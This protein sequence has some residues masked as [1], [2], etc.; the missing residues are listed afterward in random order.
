MRIAYLAAGAAN[1]FCGSCLHD[2]TLA[3]ALIAQ[4]ADI[5]LIPT[6][7]PMRVDEPSV[8]QQRVF[9][10]GVNVYLQDKLPWLRHAPRFLDRWLDSSWLL[11]QLSR[12]N[13]S[14]DASKLG[15]LTVSTLE[16]ESGRVRKELD[17][18]IDWLAT[19]VRP[20][21]VHLSNALLL[22]MTQ[23]L[24]T[25]L[26]A[27]VVC[28]LSGEDIFLEKLRPPYYE[29]SL[30]LMRERA[31]AADHFVALNRYYADAMTEL[32]QLDPQ[33][34]SVVPHG[35]KLAGHGTRRERHD[36]TVTVGYLARICHDKGLHQLVEAFEH[37]LRRDDMP[38][39]RLRV[40]GYLGRADRPYLLQ[41]EKRIAAAGWSDR[42]EYLGELS[43][44][45]KIEFLQSLDLFSVP[46]V[47]RESKGLSIIEAL[48]NGVSVVQPRHGSFPEII[49]STGGGELFAPDDPADLARVLSAL[50]TN[51]ERRALLGARGQQAIHA[52]FNDR[53]MAEKTLAMYHQVLSSPAS[54][55]P[56]S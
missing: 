12:I 42:F 20:D 24:K 14:V 37:L 2:N 44:E 48:A 50:I 34:V 23:Q 54:P 51:P 43:R 47:Y 31:R 41:L 1:M 4:G 40:A 52:Q 19:D 13:L 27:K 15:S 46:T 28:G 38:P 3:A 35:I 10:G 7:T 5:L 36:G 56:R 26:H 55:S 30:R 49:E 8:S 32:L 11:N 53:A 17:K 21:V 9:F 25:R 29:Q 39:L 6:Y 18:L 33:R 22:G 16:G 45:Q